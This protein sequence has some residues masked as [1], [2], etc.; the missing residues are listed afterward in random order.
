VLLS[1]PGLATWEQP[2][3]R[4]GYT[5]A[6][7]LP[8]PLCH[9][10][11]LSERAP[12]H[13]ERIYPLGLRPSRPLLRTHADL[14]G[15]LILG[16]LHS[17]E[18]EAPGTSGSRLGPWIELENMVPAP[19]ASLLEASGSYRLGCGGTSPEPVGD[20]DAVYHRPYP[21]RSAASR[22]RRAKSTR[23]KPRVPCASMDAGEWGRCVLG[24][25]P[26]RTRLMI[27]CVKRGLRMERAV[28]ACDGLAAAA[29]PHLCASAGRRSRPTWPAWVALG[30]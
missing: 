22:R 10:W 6:P 20:S 29:A 7:L 28:R 13:Q 12:F 23:C 26:A 19:Q 18:C 11:L 14:V 5:P 27:Y 25:R 4:I 21:L 24:R 30:L 17:R 16:P 8:A 9:A 1:H 3:T 2:S 15:R